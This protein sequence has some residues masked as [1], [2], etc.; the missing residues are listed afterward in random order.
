MCI[1]NLKPTVFVLLQL[2]LILCHVHVL[3][4]EKILGEE[5]AEFDFDGLPGAQH[6]FKVYVPGNTE[7]CFFQPVAQGAKL[8][9]TFEE[10][11]DKQ[12]Q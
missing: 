1:D 11:E 10:T 7:E 5:N 6:E 8:H 3:N 9:V 12:Q 2:L 4:G